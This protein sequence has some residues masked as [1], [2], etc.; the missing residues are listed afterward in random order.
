LCIPE[1]ILP[2]P[3]LPT[4]QDVENSKFSICDSSSYLKYIK[5]INGLKIKRIQDYERE[6]N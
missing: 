2:Q 1:I 5:I 3:D 4:I 6:L